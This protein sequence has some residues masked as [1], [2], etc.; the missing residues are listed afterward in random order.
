[1]NIGLNL[2][3]EM[4]LKQFTMKKPVKEHSVSKRFLANPTQYQLFEA[5]CHLAGP[6]VKANTVLL[7]REFP[8][9]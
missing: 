2:A 1:V 5:S 9:L 7:T 8:L 6:P 3:S 4:P